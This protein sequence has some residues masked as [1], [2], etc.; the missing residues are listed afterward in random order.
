MSRSVLKRKTGMSMKINGH[1]YDDIEKALDEVKDAA[2][3]TIII[4]NTIIGKGAGETRRN[5]PY[6]R[7][8][9]W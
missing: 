4:A 8:T 6:P 5:T 9:S 2:K 1:C 7:C 3:P